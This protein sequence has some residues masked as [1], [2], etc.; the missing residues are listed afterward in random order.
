[1]QAKYLPAVGFVPC[2]FKI[3]DEPGVNEFYNSIAW[4][5]AE[6]DD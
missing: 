6:W 3:I 1:M 5:P 2:R 4:K